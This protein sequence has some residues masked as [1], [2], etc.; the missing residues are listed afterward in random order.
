MDLPGLR[1]LMPYLGGGYRKKSNNA[2]RFYGNNQKNPSPPHPSDSC[3]LSSLILRF[4]STRTLHRWSASIPGFRGE[5]SRTLSAHR[6][7]SLG[8]I[9]LDPGEEA[10]LFAT[11]ITI[12]SII[13]PPKKS[14][15]VCGSSFFIPCETSVRICQ[16]LFYPPYSSALGKGSKI[17]VSKVFTHAGR[18]RRRGICRWGRYRRIGLDICRRRRPR[19]CPIAKRLPRS[20]L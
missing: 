18:S 9:L 16:S 1:R 4:A 15:V 14:L 6:T 11:P 13:F 3:S 12:L 19:A 20:I 17:G 2:N 7:Q 10:M 5:A 8:R